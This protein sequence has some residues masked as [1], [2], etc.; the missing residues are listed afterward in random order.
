MINIFNTAN[1]SNIDYTVEQHIKII[2]IN[3]YYR[4][5]NNYETI[6]MNAYYKSRTN[7]EIIRKLRSWNMY[8]YIETQ[9]KEFWTKA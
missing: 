3:A 6:Y 8:K 5:K 9:R 1:N 7:Y 2:Y 4:S